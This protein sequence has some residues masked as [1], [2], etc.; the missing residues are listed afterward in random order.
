MGARARA[1]AAAVGLA[2]QARRQTRL[3][4][5]GVR[6]LS[7]ILPRLLFGEEHRVLQLLL[8]VFLLAYV[9]FE[10]LLRFL[11]LGDAK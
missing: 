8:L 6:R 10:V 1:A 11:K 3:S 5:G 4:E 7:G 2:P 9:K